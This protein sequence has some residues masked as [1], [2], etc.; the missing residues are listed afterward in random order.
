MAHVI[1]DLPSVAH[2]ILLAVALLSHRWPCDDHTDVVAPTPGVQQHTPL[3]APG[4]L[5]LH[6]LPMESIFEEARIYF[7][8]IAN[9]SELTNAYSPRILPATS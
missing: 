9:A 8:R 1:I 4:K 2:W 5:P 3:P 7:Y 6:A